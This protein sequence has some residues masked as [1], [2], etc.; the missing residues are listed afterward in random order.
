MPSETITRAIKRGTGEIE[1]VTFEE[2]TYEGYGPSGIAIMIEALTDN[3]NRTTAEVRHM[4]TRYGGSL[5]ESG[6]VQWMFTKKGII[7]IPAAG[8][9]EDKLMEASID[10]GAEDVSNEGDSFEVSCQPNDLEPLKK[11]LS[12]AG[13]TI[14]SSEVS[15]EPST[16]IDVSDKAAQVLKLIEMIE[17]LDDVQNVYSNLD[18]SDEAMQKING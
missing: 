17:D 8:V 6:C 18:I 14:E 9:D 3:R 10:A 11:A 16:T 12:E 1:G 15:M 5:G 4:L 13:F 2:V 7:V